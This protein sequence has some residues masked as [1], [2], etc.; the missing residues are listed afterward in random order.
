MI[1]TLII[2]LSI[3]LFIVLWVIKAEN[4][5][6]RMSVKIGESESG[7]DVALTYFQDNGL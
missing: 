2:I 1:P 5:F 7:I 6:R 4:S 3:I